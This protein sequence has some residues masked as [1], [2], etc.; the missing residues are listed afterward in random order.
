VKGSTL[1]QAE[2]LAI[3]GHVAIMLGQ[4]AGETMVSVAIANEIKEV[5]AVR[6]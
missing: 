2:G 4:A 5:R 3:G 6:V 1:Y